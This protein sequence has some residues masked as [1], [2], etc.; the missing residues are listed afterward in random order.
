MKDE[1]G[2][3]EKMGAFLLCTL[4]G[5]WISKANLNSINRTLTTM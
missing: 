2:L 5:A 3:G 4:L 1:Y